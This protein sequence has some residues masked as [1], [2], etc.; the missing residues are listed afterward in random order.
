MKLKCAE[1][2]W[3]GDKRYYG[4]PK[5]K[6]PGK[7]RCQTLAVS[8]ICYMGNAAMRRQALTVGGVS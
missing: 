4:V 5:E 1:E 3:F 2:Q 7:V 6:L 8:S